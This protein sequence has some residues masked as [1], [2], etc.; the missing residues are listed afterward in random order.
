MAVNT[1]VEKP[2]PPGTFVL[3]SLLF[4]HMYMPH[5][6]FVFLFECETQNF[7]K[8]QPEENNSGCND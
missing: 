5:N 7:R 2:C 6:S 1:A 4:Y 8:K 3:I